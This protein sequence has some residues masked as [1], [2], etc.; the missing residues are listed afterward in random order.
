MKRMLIMAAAA[1]LTILPARAAADEYPTFA[2]PNGVAANANTPGALAT[3]PLAAVPSYA[4][5][6][7]PAAR[8][9]ASAITMPAPE[10]RST[11]AAPMSTAAF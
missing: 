8:I 11:P 3:P 9:V 1:A 5:P 6:E 2:T 10:S 4:V 7:T